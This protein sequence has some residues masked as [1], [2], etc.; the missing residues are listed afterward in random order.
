[1]ENREISGL[2]YETADLMEIAGEDPF[3][4]RSYRNAATVIESFPERVADIVA[5]PARDVTTI[6]GIGKGLAAV[7]R[8]IQER[9][10]FE[11]R[12]EML[13]KYPPTAL[14]LL[15]IQGLGPKSIALLYQHYR[16]STID[17]L[18][19]IC[20]EG[21]L[22]LLPRMGE[23]LEQ[24]V[25]RSIELYKRSAS[26]FLIDFADR[27]AA[28]LTAYLAE[29][30]GVDRITPAGSLRRGKETI[31]DVDL[32]VTGPDADPALEHFLKFPKVREVLARGENK[33]SAKIGHEGLQVDVRVL[34]R[35]SYGSALQYFTGS[36]EHSVALRTRA[37][38]RGLKLSEYGLFRT[39]DDAR[40]AGET[41]EEVYDHLGLK[42]IPPELR[43]NTG[44]I[45]AAAAEGLPELVELAQ[46]R[47]DVHM[48][49]TA[50]DGRN[51]IAE[52][53]TAAGAA[54]YQYLAITDHSKALAMANGLDERRLVEQIAE[55]RRVAED[56]PGLTIFAGCECDIRQDGSLDLADD[57][58]A[59]LDLVIGSVH[60]Y[61]NQDAAQM[62][63]RLL[64]AL[65]N[66]NLDILGHPTGRLLLRRDPFPFDF[67]RIA[68]EAGRR[69]VR[70]EINASPERLDLGADLLRAAKAKGVRFV[71]STDTHHLRHLE[72]M[73]YGVLTA[74]RGWLGPA[75]VLNTRDAAG[76]RAALRR[77]SS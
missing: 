36:K 21:K 17:D 27:A 74:R 8:E 24:K 70:F 42:W 56:F 7:L 66:P 69:G 39:A 47:G 51:S 35:A 52:L 14:E 61:M 64:R 22:R 15:K 68:S 55:I 32:L 67:D 60:S 29:L 26:R 73:K 65:E 71:V 9:G 49:T 59:E 40:V 77:N 28:E 58:L 6:R 19:R 5:D 45:E 75:D 34:D 48:H 53:A 4:I 33:A 3:R 12:D 50:T 20:R 41:E 63:D 76:F 30:P 72:N 57:A 43:E 54:G 18:E 10:S 11:R 46:I 16:V 44:E 23:K 62:T 1:M 25:L 13:E 38:K 2:L 37:I 31:G